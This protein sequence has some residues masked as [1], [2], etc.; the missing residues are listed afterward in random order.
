MKNVILVGVIIV[1]LAGAAFIFLRGGGG[2]T[3]QIP[4]GETILTLCMACKNVQEMDKKEY[5]DNIREKQVELAKAGNPMAKAYLTCEQCGKD[6]VTEAMKCEQCGKVFR[7]GAVQ[8]DY[9]D[10]CPECKYSPTEA[11]YKERTGG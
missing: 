1:C 3:S 4:E 6:A 10:K 9:A 7:K 5:Y 8:G 11:R 2:G